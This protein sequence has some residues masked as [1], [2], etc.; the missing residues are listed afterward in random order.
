MAGVNAWI[1]GEKWWNPEGR[2]RLPWR[3]LSGGLEAAA[4]YQGSWQYFDSYHSFTGVVTIV[5]LGQTQWTSAYAAVFLFLIFILNYV[6]V[7]TWL[8][9][10]QAEQTSVISVFPHCV[11]FFLKFKPLYRFPNKPYKLCLVKIRLGQQSNVDLFSIGKGTKNKVQIK[12]ES[13]QSMWT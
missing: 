1:M 3:L 12:R 6:G 2:V 8:S 7:S 9:L 11:F 4:L 13:V 10:P 5:S